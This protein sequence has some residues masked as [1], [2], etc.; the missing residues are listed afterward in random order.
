MSN[1]V[2]DILKW[3]SVI[4][5]PALVLLVNT[6]GNIWGLQHTVEISATISAVG[7]FLGAIIQVSSAK[8]CK[9]QEQDKKDKD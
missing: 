8:Y 3:I 4:V 5:V 2:Y 9:E 1:K 6:V 7:V